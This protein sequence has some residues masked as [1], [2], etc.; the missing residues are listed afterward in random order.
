LSRLTKFSLLWRGYLT[1]AVIGIIDYL[2]GPVL[3]MLVFYLIPIIIITWFVGKNAGIVISITSCLVTFIPEIVLLNKYSSP[4]ILSLNFLGTLSI[5]IIAIFT[6]SSL[7]RA[8]N[9]SINREMEVAREVQ[10]HLLP[11]TMPQLKTLS[12][13]CCCKPTQIVSGD[14]Y[15]F[16]P[17]QP[18]L[19]GIAVGDI[20]GKGISA[21][22]LMAN[23]QGLLRSHALLHREDLVSVMSDINRSLCTSTDASKFATLFYGV[24]DDNNRTLTYVNAGHN[25]PMVLRWKNGQLESTRK[26]AD[27]TMSQSANGPQHQNNVEIIRLQTENTVI[28]LLPT[29]IYTRK[30]LQLYPGDVIVIFTDGLIDARDYLNNQYGEERL[31]R[32]IE[33]NRENPATQLHDLIISDFEDFS[34]GETQFDDTTLFVAKVD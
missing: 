14:Y 24:Y 16:I 12:Y 3:S 17:L 8:T 21:A 7:L 34:E 15:D 25:P 18:H 27:G 4:L 2:T 33:V 11:Q 31:L 29:S 19:L 28:G 30:S 5:F 1:V 13:A 23:L 22:L 10:F 20:C 6:I 26:I 32:L 9:D